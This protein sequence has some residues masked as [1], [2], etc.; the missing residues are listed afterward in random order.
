MPLQTSQEEYMRL[1]KSLQNMVLATGFPEYYIRVL[2]IKESCAASNLKVLRRIV[3]DF[4]L[5]ATQ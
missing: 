4:T 5:H 2:M 1:Q 3:M